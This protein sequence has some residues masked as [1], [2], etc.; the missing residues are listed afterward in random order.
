MIKQSLTFTSTEAKFA[1]RKELEKPVISR[2]YKKGIPRTFYAVVECEVGC[3]EMQDVQLK[4]EVHT[5]RA[6]GQK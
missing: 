1:K 3:A 5:K 4:N 2:N 6:T